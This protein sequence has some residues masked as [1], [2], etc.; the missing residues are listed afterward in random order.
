L[1]A[2]AAQAAPQK[3]ASVNAAATTADEKKL[4]PGVVMQAVPVDPKAGPV[5]AAHKLAE[6]KPAKKPVAKPVEPTKLAA[7]KPALKIDTPA[8][9]LRTASDAN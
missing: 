4:G 7:A 8:P 6:A 2:P 5:T 1:P 3:L 9:A